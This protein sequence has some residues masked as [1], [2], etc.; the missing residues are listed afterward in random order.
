KLTLR[1]EGTKGKGTHDPLKFLPQL[2]DTRVKPQWTTPRPSLFI[3][4]KHK[5]NEVGTD[6]QR[7]LQELIDRD[8]KRKRLQAPQRASE[9]K[10]ESAVHRKLVDTKKQREDF[11]KALV[12]IV[13]NADSDEATNLSNLYTSQGNIPPTT[14]DL[15]T[16]VEKDILRYYYYIHNGIDT[17]YVAELDSHRINDT[18][19]RLPSELRR[20][21]EPLVNS[22]T[23]EMKED[24]LLSVKKAIVDFVLR[25][26]RE[27]QEEKKE[28]V[29]IHRQELAVLPKPWHASFVQAQ[30]NMEKN[31]HSIN[32]TMAQVLNMWHK[33]VYKY[34]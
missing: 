13:T 11:R 10:A 26:P 3:P 25:D 15:P 17:Q 22:L 32:S 2:P 7:F 23:D 18:L 16:S 4:G 29:L 31:L 33:S 30:I 21:W 24:Y 6:S 19:S 28:E 12:D 14:A 8:P 34:V 27:S 5:L 9:S 1:G 20:S